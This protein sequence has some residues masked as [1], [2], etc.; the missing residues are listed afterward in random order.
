MNMTEMYM[1]NSWKSDLNGV[2]GG[3]LNC[4]KCVAQTL[5]LLWCIFV[6][7]SFVGQRV[8]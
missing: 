8:T 4:D 1:G 5:N 2:F 6:T 3:K 7:C